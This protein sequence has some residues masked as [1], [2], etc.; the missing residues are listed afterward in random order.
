[1]PIMKDNNITWPYEEEM[2][3]FYP[4]KTKTFDSTK[5]TYRNKFLISIRLGVNSR[6]IT[7][8]SSKKRSKER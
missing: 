2:K 1:M 8:Q 3:K 7:K 4:D 6:K 5:A